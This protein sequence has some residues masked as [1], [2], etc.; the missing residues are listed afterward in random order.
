MTTRRSLQGGLLTIGQE[1]ALTAMEMPIKEDYCNESKELSYRNGTDFNPGDIFLNGCGS[2]NKEGA[3][4]AV[5]RVSEASCAQCHGQA[6]SSV[7][8]QSIYGGW[9]LSS[10]FLLPVLY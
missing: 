1:W 10:H 5:T 9:Q 4:L 3:G 6:V 8:A 2:S 7:T